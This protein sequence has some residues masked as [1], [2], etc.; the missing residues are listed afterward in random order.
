MRQAR[1]M[2]QQ[3]P[4]S[5]L[6]YFLGVNAAV[7]REVREGI[8]Q[9]VIQLEQ[10]LLDGAQKSERRVVLGDRLHTEE[11]VRGNLVSGAA[12]ALAEPLGPNDVLLFDQS[13]GEAGSIGRP[14]AV[15]DELS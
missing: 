3:L 6:L 15:A 14:H 12:F 4:I 2:A 13:N 7:N 5:D 10:S 11:R 9:P 1:P 8:Y